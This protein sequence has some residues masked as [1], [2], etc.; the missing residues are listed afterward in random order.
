M[1]LDKDILYKNNKIYSPKTCIFVPQRINQLFIKQQRKRG[2]HSI[3]V[4]FTSDKTKLIVQCRI[5]EGYGSKLE[6]LG[7]FPLS[8]PFHAFYTYKIFKENYI[9]QI[10]DE[11]KSLIPQKLY[12]AL[13]RYEVEIND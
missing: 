9:K 13:Y 11:Y 4:S 12:D 6:H 8:E 5:N 2:T 3:G 10:A 7:R 1:E